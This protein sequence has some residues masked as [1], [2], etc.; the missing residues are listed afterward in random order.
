MKTTRELVYTVR[1]ALYNSDAQDAED[2]TMFADAHNALDELL[3]L[4]LP[5][6]VDRE[7]SEKPDG[8]IK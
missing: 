5:T 7:Q 1:Q 8:C 4:D 6:N 2:S 3:K